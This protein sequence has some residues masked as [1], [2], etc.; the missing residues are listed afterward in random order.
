[1][2]VQCDAPSHQYIVSASIHNG[3]CFSDVQVVHVLELEL[4]VELVTS[5][6]T[7]ASSEAKV[8]FSLVELVVRLLNVDAQLNTVAVAAVAA[9]RAV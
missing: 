1:V 9:V 3:A 2:I 5:S 7:R 4:V 6:V 8:D